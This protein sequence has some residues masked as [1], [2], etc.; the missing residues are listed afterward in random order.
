MH[1]QQQRSSQDGFHIILMVVAVVVIGVVGFVGYMLYAE[2]SAW[3]FDGQKWVAARNAPA[4]E[5]PLEIASPMDVKQATSK[6]YPGQVR[7][8]DFKPHG[9]LSVDTAKDTKVTVYAIRDAKLVAAA[10]YRENDVVQYLLDFIDP[11]GIKYRYDHIAK[12]SPE[13]AKYTDLL[14]LRDND[15]RT[16]DI[17]GPTIKKGSTVATEVGQAGNVGFDLG[18]YD[19][20]TQNEASKTELYRTE[21]RRIDDKEQSFYSVCWFDLLPPADRTIVNAL[22][23]RSNQQE[24]KSSDYC[25]VQ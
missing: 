24:G 10:K 25:S 8:T 1:K 20:R 3:R 5:S 7:G 16:S 23:S 19:L 17:D 21:Q 6:L 22:P 11:C 15:S 18:V 14:P 9:G 13:L 12:V 4:C 2:G